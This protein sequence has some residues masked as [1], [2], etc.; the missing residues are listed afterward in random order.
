[1][2]DWLSIIV[3]H[4]CNQGSDF[5]IKQHHI[6]ATGINNLEEEEEEEEEY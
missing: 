6:A 4:H 3:M 1:M 5:L 2:H